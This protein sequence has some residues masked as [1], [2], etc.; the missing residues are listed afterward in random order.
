[1]DDDLV[2]SAIDYLGLADKDILRPQRGSLPETELRI[3]SW[4]SLPGHDADFG[5]GL[6]R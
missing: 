5:W 2:R 3:V 1:M 6:R 4:L